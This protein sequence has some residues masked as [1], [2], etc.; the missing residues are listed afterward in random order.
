[1][2]YRHLQGWGVTYSVTFT[3]EDRFDYIVFVRANFLLC[4]NTTVTFFARLAG[5][6]D[7]EMEFILKKSQYFFEAAVLLLIRLNNGFR[8]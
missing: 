7:V 3:L 2:N 1:M 8:L 6:S 4:F 5:M